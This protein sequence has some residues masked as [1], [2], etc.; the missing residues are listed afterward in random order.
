MPG[1]FFSNVRQRR[2]VAAY[3][4]TAAVAGVAICLHSP[5]TASALATALGTQEA[6]TPL[7]LGVGIERA[8]VVGEPH[9][10]RVMLTT[11]DFV[12]ITI[13]QKGA[14]IAAT[15]VRPD[16][17]KLLTVDT[18]KELF[19]QETIVVI[20]EASGLHPIQLQAA[21]NGRYLI[22]VDDLR[23]ATTADQ[24]RVAAERAYERG[25]AVYGANQ[26]AA[27]PQALAALQQ[28]LDRYR[29]LGDRAG[30]VK[31]AI[32]VAM[33]K[34]SLSTP[35]LLASAQSAEA[36]ARLT[37][38]HPT[39]ALAL[40][41]LGIAYDETGDRAAAVRAFEECV[42]LARAMGDTRGEEA[43]L[44]ALGIVYGRTGDAEQAAATFE[45]S[46]TLN[47]AEGGGRNEPVLLN[48][49]GIAYKDLGQYDKSLDFYA[50]ALSRAQ[51]GRDLNAEAQVL[52]NM[53]NV[54]R[55]IGRHDQALDLHTRALAASRANGSRPNEAR[56][57]NTIGL[58]HYDLGD[59]QRSLD[60][61]RQA[62]AIRRQLADKAAEAA[63]LNG[64][65]RALH[66][67]GKSDEALASLREALAIRQAM[68]EQY[69]QAE[70]LQHLALVERDRNNLAEALRHIEASADLDETLRARI[71]SPELR[72]SYVAAAQDTYELFI[73]ILQRRHAVDPTDGHA[74]AALN[75]SER[76]RARVLLESLLDARVDL[77]QGIEASLLERE[78]LLQRQLNEAATQ[79]SRSL[80]RSQGKDSSAPAADSV[81]R[82]AAEYQRLQAQIRQ[83]SPRYA[84]V[85]QPQPLDAAAI[86]QSVVDD[87]TVLLEFALGEEKSWLWAVT[88][89]TVVSVEL[90]ARR[91]IE[92]AARALYQSLTARQKQPGENSAG[93][94]K[95]VAAAD[96]ALERQALDVSH[97]LLGGI[98]QQLSTEWRS[99]RL[100]IAASGVLE[101]LPFAVLRAP[102]RTLL[103]AQHEIVT[104]PSASVLATLRRELAQRERASRP[105]VILADPV[106][107][108]DDPR[109]T[110]SRSTN[111]LS[112]RD[113]SASR[114]EAV[115]DA[116]YARS[117]LSRLPFSREEANAIASLAGV[118]TTLK[119]TDFQASRAL[120]LS[121]T[122]SGHRIVHFATHGVVDSERPS[123]S[124]LILSLVDERGMRQNGY[125]RLH[126][127]YNMRLDADLVVLSACQTALGKE[128]K[129]EG[130]VGLTRAFIYAGAPR[131]VA[132]LWQVND[133]ATAELMKKFYRGLLQQRL[134][135]AAAL[136]AA[137]IEM[138]R[139]PRWKS[140]YYW[141]GFVLQGEWR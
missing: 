41:V 57:L 6:A 16:G 13:Q 117:D 14:D 15:V 79:L 141:A 9:H 137:Q 31:A 134:R 30:E 93:Y 47:R 99:K 82:L 66:R 126:D 51:A 45:R 46:L 29:Q 90:P 52:N 10:Y 36:L 89:R 135:P 113:D 107:G 4:L 64:V 34:R 123:L 23:A 33:V 50:Q 22:R 25:W 121:G 91:E 77:R 80:A 114:T 96:A 75:I 132:S 67:L 71:T 138:S 122:L 20:A 32:Q 102:N 112:T 61:H 12:R 37:G 17:Q 73:D 116:L 74:A 125:L 26:A 55:L 97:L 62:L 19:R 85:T 111:N 54:E 8:I 129:G 76:G 88:P 98:S 38:D 27:Y 83:Q 131:V 104:I 109:L 40:R 120:A 42:A 128:V 63:S 100:A 119:A 68:R 118:A 65:G 69:G 18:A 21:R 95:R 44:N 39:T 108:A 139:D 3:L 81:E 35:D 124:A 1:L 110:G 87:G 49:L 105:L 2:L 130:L 106:F 94:A 127:I 72:A 7:S 115:V 133:L 84:S 11:G 103:G 28:A 59:Y 70:T 92:R 101:Y 58:T 78:R 136:R 86:Q 24:D 140:P 56:S 43:G 48:N 53:G 60:Y 5:L